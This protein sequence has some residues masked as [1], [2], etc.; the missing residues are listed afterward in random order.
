MNLNSNDVIL[1]GIHYLMVE[2]TIDIIRQLAAK[3]D[4]DEDAEIS[5][6]KENFSILPNTNTDNTTNTTTSAATNQERETEYT[7]LLARCDALQREVS[8]LEAAAEQHSAENALAE[9]A[10]H[11]LSIILNEIIADSS[12]LAKLPTNPTTSPIYN[13]ILANIVAIANSPPK[14][15]TTPPVTRQKN[16]V[17]SIMYQYKRYYVNESTAEVFDTKIEAVGIFDSSTKTIDF[18]CDDFE[19]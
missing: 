10:T 16:S 18:Y 15:P 4:F 5:L 11:T 6:F 14:I 3:Y 1:K 13:Q 19:M 2:N 17:K 9:E 12:T 7:A 8:A